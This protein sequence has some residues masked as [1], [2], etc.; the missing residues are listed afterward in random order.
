M[1]GPFD[2]LE[3]SVK[4]LLSSWTEPGQKTERFPVATELDRTDKVL[5]SWKTPYGVGAGLR[6]M[7]NTCY[8][9][10]ALQCLTYTPPLAT[11]MLALQHRPSCA[12]ARTCMMCVM[13]R[14][15]TRALRHPGR[16]IQPLHALLA[17]FHREKQ[18]DAHEYL[19]FIVQAMQKVDVHSEDRD[20]MQHIFGGYWRSQIKCLHCGSTSD[21]FDP[22]L[23]IPLDIQAAESV[24]QA[25]TQCAE[26][27][28]LSGENAYHCGV[29]LQKVP[30]SKTLSLH[31]CPKVLVFLLKRF[32]DF[33]GEKIAKRV[34]YSEWLDMQPYVSEPNTGPGLYTLYAVLVHAGR[35]CHSGHYFSYVKA[36]DG[37]WYEM[38]DN[39]VTACDRT[40][41]LAQ[42]AYVLF[43]AQT[44]L[45]ERDNS[46]MSAEGT[47][48]SVHKDMCAKLRALRV[49]SHREHIHLED[50][51]SH[52]EQTHEIQVKESSLDEWKF[53]QEQNQPKTEWNLR[54]VEWSLPANAVLM[55]RSKY[56]AELSETHSGDENLCPS[57][58]ARNIS[59]HESSTMGQAPRLGGSARATKK[60]KKKNRNNN[61]GKRTVLVI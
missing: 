53:L 21:T 14:H 24:E 20:L 56:T 58:A 33:T 46:G 55:H 36:G 25:L 54:K 27:E 9:N 60:K 42:D 11:H 49:A 2:D 12:G 18:E 41:V 47:L 16:V 50:M 28:E 39:K 45:L 1:C 57:S 34:Q 30:A 51:L 15:I 23:D 26:P 7:G 4:T 22:Y 8:V 19:T 43:Y 5:P 31:T 13:Q 52:R 29:C 59:G 32:S 61:Q 35:T 44:S 17:D 10:A 48:G 6:N 38:N 37:H 40:A 3:H